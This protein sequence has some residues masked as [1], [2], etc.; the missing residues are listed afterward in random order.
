MLAED[1]N[2]KA[3]RRVELHEKLE[4]TEVNNYFKP[5]PPKEKPQ[6]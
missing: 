2:L 4:Q 5:V 3:R 6:L 1:T